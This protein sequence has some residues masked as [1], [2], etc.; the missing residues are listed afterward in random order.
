[1]LVRDGNT[2]SVDI[3]N[4]DIHDDDQ[5][6]ERSRKWLQKD[7]FEEKLQHESRDAKTY[8]FTLASPCVDYRHPHI[9]DCDKLCVDYKLCIHANTKN[10]GESAE[11]SKVYVR[12]SLDRGVNHWCDVG[13]R[14]Q[15]LG[16]VF[17]CDDKSID[18]HI[19]H[20]VLGR[21]VSWTMYFHVWRP[22]NFERPKN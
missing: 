13:P 5:G 21:I 7:W 18:L 14:L 11:T 17:E 20:D 4:S 19:D 22:L 2:T 16:F 3:D 15:E 1:M 9:S 8:D 6:Y 10:F 12:D